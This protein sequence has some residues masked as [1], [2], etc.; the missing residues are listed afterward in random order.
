MFLIWFLNTSYAHKVLCHEKVHSIHVND[1][2][3]INSE[4]TINRVI[5]AENLS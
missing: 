5:V 4:R 1:K 3:T 2:F